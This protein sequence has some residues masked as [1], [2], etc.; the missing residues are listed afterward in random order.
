MLDRQFLR[1][2]GDMGNPEAWAF[3]AII[4][5]VDG[6]YARPAVSGTFAGIESVIKAGKRLVERGAC[7]V[8]TTCGF[9]VLRQRA[10]E[11]ALA[12]PMWTSTLLSDSALQRKL[13]Q[14]RR[15]AILIID[16]AALN[17][18]VRATAGIPDDELIFYLSDE[19]HL[20]RAIFDTAFPLDPPTTRD[21]WVSVALSVQSAHP[22]MG[23]W[24]FERGNMPL[25]AGAV[26]SATGMSVYDA[27]VTSNVLYRSVQP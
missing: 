9:L 21:E 12:V 18:M 24:L 11:T 10:L 3:P 15:V 25:Y 1:P 20:R 17:P 4:E 22:S 8:T 5:R 14:S 26:G 27:L 16:K 6:A 7:A 23:Q 2:L 19:S 13:G